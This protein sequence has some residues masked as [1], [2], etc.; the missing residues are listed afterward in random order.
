MFSTIVRCV[1]TTEVSRDPSDVE[2]SSTGV[3]NTLLT[4]VF[5]LGTLIKRAGTPCTPACTSR[6]PGQDWN[7]DGAAVD[8]VSVQHMAPS[9]CVVQQAQARERQLTESKIET[10]DQISPYFVTSCPLTLESGPRTSTRACEWPML[11]H[12]QLANTPPRFERHSSFSDE[13]STQEPL[14]KSASRMSSAPSS[15]FSGTSTSTEPGPAPAPGPGPRSVC[16]L[17]S[18]PHGK[19]QTERLQRGGQLAAKLQER[20][21]I[22]QETLGKPTTGFMLGNLP[23]RIT[24]KDVCDAIDHMGFYG[25]YNVCRMANNSNQKTPVATNI[26]YAFIFFTRVEYATA[27]NDSFDEFRFLGSASMKQ[28]TLRPARLPCKVFG[29]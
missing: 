25:T 7:R 8:W 11:P 18:V 19:L 9:A 13:I 20:D 16:D 14:P 2:A 3:A 23:D 24:K 15:W 12:S 17:G 27:F 5:S 4:K 22:S 21:S 10:K 28:C 6:G 1:D 29:S 26:G